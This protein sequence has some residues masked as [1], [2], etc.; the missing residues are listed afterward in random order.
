MEKCAICG[1]QLYRGGDDYA[2][3][4]VEGRGHATEHHYVAERFFGRSGNRPGTTREAIFKQCPWDIER[5]KDVYCYECHEV[6]LHNPVLLPEDIAGFA[7]LV[8][9]RGFGEEHKTEDRERL[10][11]RI[12]LLHEVFSAGLRVLL[13]G[14]VSSSVLD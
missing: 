4:T 6:L 3:P 7:D 10:A 11:G 8:R 13:G 14:D 9:R 1:C 2:K 12:V 5:K